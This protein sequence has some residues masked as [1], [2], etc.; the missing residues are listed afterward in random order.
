M[1]LK[2]L[3]VC[4]SVLVCSISIMLPGYAD[5]Q[6]EQ[7]YDLEIDALPLMAAV[8][9]LS[10]E[11][12]IEVLYFSDIGEG[13]TSTPVKGKYTPRDALQTM[14]V[15]TDLEVVSLDEEGAVAI[16]P[17]HNQGGD[18]DSKNSRPAPVLIAQNQTSAV[19]NQLRQTKPAGD[20]ISDDEWLLDEV[21][22]TASR[23]G[24]S[25]Q[26]STLSATVLKGDELDASSPVSL[27]DFVNFL[28]SVSLIGNGEGRSRLTIRGV[29]ALNL[30]G[31]ATVGTY[32]N[33]SFVGN[34][35]SLTP[36]LAT[37]DLES[38]EVL[39]GPQGT[40]FGRASLGGTLRIIT[41]RPDTMR[42]SGKV[43]LS[44]SS[45]DKGGTGFD[46]AAMLN[47]PLK[48]NRLALRLVGM[49]RT[50]PGY[51]DNPQAGTSEINESRVNSGRASL[52]YT[53]NDNLTIEGS[54]TV[55]H[56]V[57]GSAAQFDPRLPEF[58]VGQ[59][60]DGVYD[61]DLS[62]TNLLVTYR[63]PTFDIVLSS[64][65]F[66]RDTHLMNPVDFPAFG[67]ANDQTIDSEPESLS[68]EVRLVSTVDGRVSWVAGAYWSKDDDDFRL[69]DVDSN[70]INPNFELMSADSLESY[71]VFGEVTIAMSD[72]WSTTIGGRYNEQE[73]NRSGIT[74]KSNS[75]S[76]KLTLAYDPNDDAMVYV[77][78]ARGFRAG[79]VNAFITPASPPE[80]LPFQTFEPDTV[81]N[82]E[83][84][85]KT[86]LND[87]RLLLNAVAFYIDW[88]DA[89]VPI[90]IPG[91][92]PFRTPI[93]TAGDISSEGLEIE[94]EADPIDGLALSVSAS[95][96]QTEFDEDS[97]AL[98]VSKG[99]PFPFSFESNLSAAVN[100]TFSISDRW[101]AF[102]GGNIN[103]VGR[104]Y[105]GV[106]TGEP[107]GD[108]TLTNL[109]VGLRR[110][111]WEYQLYANNAFNS[112]GLVNVES[113]RLALFAGRPDAPYRF[114]NR[115]RTIGVRLLGHF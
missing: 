28:P 109:S 7:S 58:Q 27:G 55:Q 56:G 101:D 4:V 47:F 79:G 73:L 13:V 25:L 35:S 71:S 24:E 76:P 29:S 54:V 97:V 110:G 114:I 49:H 20:K 2:H 60:F 30:T 34:E 6:Y 52:L 115:P 44:A 78:A 90:T 85:A 112:D 43:R 66:R 103:H 91:Q 100:Y 105:A 102:L 93:S 72:R 75:F 31:G 11:T 1:T 48:P 32:I 59:R 111:D 42:F 87:G 80:L 68:Q 98:G 22:V 86:T 14:L 19:Q 96:V 77:T 8:K 88:S 21:I 94:F 113:S 37:F 74:V 107:I 46:A 67:I 69:V 23:R 26:E 70:G 33:E 18:S 40:L 10:D 51:V 61:D 104:G 106:G 53:P 45:T 89:Q 63:R 62:I 50:A 39:R 84:G 108:Y 15:N 17:A 83:V 41:K 64:N 99:D 16:R 38:I 82:Y 92:P 3:V 81:W 65:L 5:E 57:L 9:A 95:W 12:G 36:E